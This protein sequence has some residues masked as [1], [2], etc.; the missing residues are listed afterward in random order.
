MEPGKRLWLNAL[1][2]STGTSE[3]SGSMLGGTGVRRGPGHMKGAKD[4]HGK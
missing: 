2:H 3:T 1:S 4:C